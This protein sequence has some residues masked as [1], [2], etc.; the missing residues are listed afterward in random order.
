MSAEQLQ[1]VV[2]ANYL[3]AMGYGHVWSAKVRQVI[4]GTLPDREL[5]LSLSDNSGGK[6]YGGLFQDEPVVGAK[7]TLHKLDKRPAA[8][9]GFVAADGTIWKLDEVSP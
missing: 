8:L 3:I 9:I 2:D 1:I 6:L 5:Q 4:A 7:L